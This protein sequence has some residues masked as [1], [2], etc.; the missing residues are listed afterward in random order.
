[1]ITTAKATKCPGCR[2]VIA[3]L[4]TFKGPSTRESLDIAFFGLLAWALYAFNQRHLQCPKCSRIWRP[5][6]RERSVVYRFV[7]AVLVAGIIM[8]LGTRAL[9]FLIDPGQR[10]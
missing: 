10:P 5:R 8:W 2:E 1:M 9:S 6:L 3:P 7:V 4:E